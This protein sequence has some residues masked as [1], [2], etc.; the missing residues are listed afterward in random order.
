MSRGTVLR[1]E[2]NP[3]SDL[4]KEK[5]SAGNKILPKWNY[6]F[7]TAI[8][9]IFLV[10]SFSLPSPKPLISMSVFL[11]IAISL[12]GLLAMAY[13]IKT[14]CAILSKNKIFKVNIKTHLALS[15][16]GGP[17]KSIII[18]GKTSITTSPTAHQ[19]SF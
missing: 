1:G 18:C 2:N 6:Q 5:N 13:A 9:L 17:A 3:H 4:L 14:T 16:L 8:T 12:L 10:L 7:L 19:S 11:G 15:S